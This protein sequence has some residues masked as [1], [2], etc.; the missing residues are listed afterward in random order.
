[1]PEVEETHSA[2][3]YSSPEAAARELARETADGIRPILDEDRN[4]EARVL[5]IK[6]VLDPRVNRREILTGFSDTLQ[7]QLEGVTISI[8]E[9]PG[10]LTRP[11]RVKLEVGA[12]SLE[13]QSRAPWD[14]GQ[15]QLS[16][17]LRCRINV[18]G[19][20]QRELN[21]KFINKPWVQ[22]Y[23]MFANERSDRALLQVRAAD[24]GQAL[25]LAAQELR[26]SIEPRLKVTSL[27]RTRWWSNQVDAQIQKQLTNGPLIID[28]FS[29]TFHTQLGDA[30]VP[31]YSRQAILI[32][33]SPPRLQRTIEQMN[34]ELGRHHAALASSWARALGLLVVIGGVYAVLNAATKG[35]YTWTLRGA[36]AVLVVL[37]IVA[38]MNM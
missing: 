36:A 23:G 1:L 18:D 10:S 26:R 30:S 25:R 28:R 12:T 16:G 14:S 33:Y 15:T 4:E 5:P 17:T 8:E 19:R 38:W 13:E 32:D 27:P 24:Q 34:A 9:G 29:Q 7:Q 31:A 20:E 35:Y 22:G 37:A 6:F 2:D 21:T 3:V 11:A